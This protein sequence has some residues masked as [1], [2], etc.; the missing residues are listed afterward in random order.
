[1]ISTATS[2]E[3]VALSGEAVIAGANLLAST[4]WSVAI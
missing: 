2:S 1:M 3:V 4:L